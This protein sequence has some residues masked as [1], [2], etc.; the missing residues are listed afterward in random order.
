MRNRRLILSV[1]LFL[2][3][4][5]T[6]TQIQAQTDPK[7]GTVAEIHQAVIAGDL[8]K[9]RVLI[10]SDSTLF[11]LKNSHGETPLILACKT[12]QVAIANFLIDKGANVNAKTANGATP[13]FFFGRDMDKYLDLVQHIIDKGGD[14]NV[15]LLLDRNWTLLLNTVALGN[16]KAAKLLI[17]HGADININDIAG[18]ILQMIINGFYSEWNKDMAVLLIESGAKLQ[19]FSYGNTELHLAAINDRTDLV[20]LLVKYGAD[21]NAVNDYK[22]TALYYAT[23]LGHHK[24]ADELIAAGA[25]KSSIVEINYG[26]APQLTQKL[27]DSEAYL[28]YLGGVS[29]GYAV[30]TKRHLLIFNPQNNEESQ[31]LHLANGCLNPD[32]LKGQEITVLITH[33]SLQDVS[34]LSDIMPGANFVL[35]YKPDNIIQPTNGLTINADLTPKSKIPP[36][37]LANPNE[38]FSMGSGVQVHT[39]AA[40]DNEMLGNSV[41]YIVETDGLKIFYAGLQAS[42]NDSLHIIKYHKDIDT[43]KSFAPIDIAILP[44]DG[45]HQDVAYEPYLY[46]IDQL[47]PKAIY[48]MGDKLVTKEHSKC[49]EVLKARNIPVAFPEGGLEIG[50]RFHFYRDSK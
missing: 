13:L 43:L 23:M 38:S 4:G 3:I 49:V 36:Y 10:N 27:R 8:N 39:T 34:Q 19:E 9:V 12:R 45:T 33:F 42:D 11:E 25:N 40:I 18:T 47:S 28:W 5:L 35:S 50:E 44:I 14:V 48:L 15:K 6:W 16:P 17:D 32:E 20:P 22:H 46:L 26:K 30:K 37:Q 7:T 1:I 21:V 31:E 41:G 2:G 29:S 24:V